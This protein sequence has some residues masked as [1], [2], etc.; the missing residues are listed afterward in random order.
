[1]CEAMHIRHR[2]WP[3]MGVCG[4]FSWLKHL[5]VRVLPLAPARPEP[6]PTFLAKNIS[7]KRTQKAWQMLPESLKNDPK[8]VTLPLCFE[9]DP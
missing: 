6:T 5:S 4:F 3:G 9:H 7:M 2:A 8:K 1:M